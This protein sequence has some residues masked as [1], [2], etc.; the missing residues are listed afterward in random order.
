[1]KLRSDALEHSVYGPATETLRSLIADIE[2]FLWFPVHPDHAD[3][4]QAVHLISE[5]LRQLRPFGFHLS[6][7]THVQPRWLNGPIEVFDGAARGR[8]DAE[9]WGDPWLRDRPWGT[10]L[11]TA[12]ISVIERIEQTPTLFNRI[13]PPLWPRAGL[14]NIVQGLLFDPPPPPEF[15]SE[16]RWAMMNHVQSNL[17]RLIEWAVAYDG[18][19][20]ESPFYSLFRLHR[21]G[22]YPLG[23][24]GH[25]FFVFSRV[26]GV[27]A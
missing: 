2:G 27:A 15:R 16:P 21:L 8:Y 6:S 12:A 20:T 22:Y 3:T 10:A 9:V 7:T 14:I 19:V 11:A 13:Q 23:L 4:T 1:V 26:R 18:T 24:E 5:H 17:W 25:E